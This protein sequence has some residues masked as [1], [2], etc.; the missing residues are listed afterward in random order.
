MTRPASPRSR[1]RPPAL[2]RLP[3]GALAR[4]PAGILARGPAGA[5][6]RLPAGVL[7]LLTVAFP[8]PWAPAWTYPLA[9]AGVLAALA[10][11]VLRWRPGP[12]LAVA[13]AIISSAFSG[14][15]PLILAAEGLF[16]LAYLLLADAPPALPGPGQW[17]RRQLPLAVAGLVAAA[18]ALAA[19][20]IRP[21]ASRWLTLAGIAAA[22]AAYLIALP[23]LRSAEHPPN[24]PASNSLTNTSD[25]D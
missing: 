17:L 19:F 9:A 23:S 24:A 10:A 2:A 16:I 7:A 18:A 6:A 13:A 25:P 11:A 1:P 20:A 15:G 5:L 3:A 8:L 21:S 14:A 12:A 22:V 4:L